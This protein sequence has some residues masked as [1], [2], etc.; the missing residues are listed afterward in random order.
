MMLST[1]PIISSAAAKIARPRPLTPSMPPLLLRCWLSSSRDRRAAR[2]LRR[3]LGHL[4]AVGDQVDQN[5]QKRH[6]DDQ[7]RPAD[8]GAATDVPA[9]E[10]VD[11]DGDDTPDPGHPD[12]EDRH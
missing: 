2:A 1:L 5:A 10:H 12:E 6:E 8:L 3:A 4:R 11:Q 9:A 7:D